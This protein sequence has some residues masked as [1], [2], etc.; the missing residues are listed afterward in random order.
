[1][2]LRGALLVAG[3]TSDAG[4]SALVA[5]I[6]RWL[7][8]RGVSVAPFK[9][10]NMSNNSV[11]TADG[12]EIGRAQAMQAHAC[13]LAPSVAFNPVLLKPGSDRTSQVVVRGQASGQVSAMSYRSRKAALLE[14]VT[15]TFAELRSR[16]DVVICEGAG[17]PAEINLRAT[18]IANMGLAQAADLPVVV[19]GDIDR[20]GVLAHLFGTVAV[21]DPADQARIAG[22]V[23]NKFRGD[24]ALLAPGL[25]RLRTLTGRPTLG[26]VPWSDGLWLDAEDSL[27]AV[28][29]GVLGR[30]SPPHGSQ[31]L[32]IAVVRSPRISNATDAEA[33]AC[34]PGV[35]VRYVTEPSRLLDADVVVLPGSKATV[36]DLAWLRSSGLADG[37]LAHAAAG[38]PVLGICGGYQMLGRRI[39]DPSGVEVPGGADVPGLG[40]LDLEVAFDPVKHLGNPTG[41][42]L[43]YPV[44]GYE[45]HHGQVVRSGDPFLLA[46]K[47]SDTGEGSDAGAVL[48]T[49]WH[50]LL[51]NDHFR[52]ALLTR[53]AAQAGRAGFRVAPATSFS[54]ERARQLDLLGDLVEQHL[55]T[56]SL[57]HVIRHGASPELPVL[58]SGL[59]E[60]R[61]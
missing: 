36:S 5:G 19:V 3:T 1:M 35:S 38:K 52:R 33:L 22:F 24:P 10:Q 55:D 41:T 49:H 29:D 37:V 25:D 31:W 30:P 20:G 8:R 28:A 47:G 21:L 6:C 45:I 15:E 13:G 57:E 58:A 48:G 27:S 2:D 26:V 23:I 54:A 61:A 17:S 32:R 4:K 14:V 53:L 56:S 11:V 43:G 51:E 50:G 46:G 18:D 9:A 40:L 44:R 59:A 42:A 12:G 60:S 7:V 39:V 16:Y 34:E